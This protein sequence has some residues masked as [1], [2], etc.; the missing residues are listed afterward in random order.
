MFEG[1][2]GGR[3]SECWVLAAAMT[4]NTSKKL[5]SVMLVMSSNGDHR[6]MRTMIV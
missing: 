6:T 5:E 3:G 4:M 1:H 2:R